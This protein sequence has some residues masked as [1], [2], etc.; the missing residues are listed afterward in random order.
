MPGFED[1]WLYAVKNAHV[2][3]QV[4]R[5]LRPLLL[6]VYSN[7]LVTPVDLVELKKSLERLL[8]Y[9]AEAGR[10]NA[11]CWATDLFFGSEI[12]WEKD[13]GEQDLPEPLHDIFAKMSEALHDTV[14]TPQIAENFGCL[15]EQLLAQL[16]QFQPSR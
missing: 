3:P 8:G 10:T 11:N 6:D 12:G 15:P 2:G 1:A 9:L 16:E 14:Q 7:V 13:W 5:E 4:S